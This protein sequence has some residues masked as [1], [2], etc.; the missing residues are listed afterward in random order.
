MAKYNIYPGVFPCHTCQEV[1]KTI[2]HYPS[3]KVLTWMCSHKHITEVS[4]N[5]KK[6][7]DHYERTR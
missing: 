7:K 1:V 4:L 5:T 6:T 3:D 2:R